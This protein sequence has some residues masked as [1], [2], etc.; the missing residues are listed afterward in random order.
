MIG[1]L[2]FK[3][4]RANNFTYD[5]YKDKIRADLINEIIK[6]FEDEDD[7]IEMHKCDTKYESARRMGFYKAIEMLKDIKSK[8]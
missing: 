5:Y 6:K 7:W 1:F 8:L 4:K 2:K 3:N